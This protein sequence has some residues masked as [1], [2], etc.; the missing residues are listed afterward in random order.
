MTPVE[1]S[2][3]AARRGAIWT[4]DHPLDGIDCLSL[5]LEFVA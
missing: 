4:G 2:A 5:S 1:P 3:C